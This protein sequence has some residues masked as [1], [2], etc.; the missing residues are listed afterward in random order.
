MKRTSFAE[1]EC[2][3][4]RVLD[5]IGEWWTLLI[6]RNVFYGINRFDGLLT[7]LEISRN[8]LT[9]RLHTLVESG[10]LE[11]RPYQENPP[12]FEYHLTAKGEELY[13]ILAAYRSWGEKWLPQEQAS[14]V[15]LIHETCGAAMTP[16]LVCSHCREAVHPREVKYRVGVRGREM[17]L[18]EVREMA[19]GRVRK[20]VKKKDSI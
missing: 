6:V 5:R 11:K 18:A 3:I 16:L 17:D 14:K 2:P 8:V 7:H 4:A 10:L 9:D 13:P 1:A 20:P 15:K 19:Q 12:R